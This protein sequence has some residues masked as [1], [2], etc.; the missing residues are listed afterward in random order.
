MV[1][2]WQVAVNCPLPHSFT[3]SDASL[4]IEDAAKLEPGLSV[5][6][7]FKNRKTLGVLLHSLS[8]KPKGDFEIRSLLAICLT[9]PKISSIYLKWLVW[10]ADYYLHPIG[11]TCELAFPP[12]AERH[13][14]RK[15]KKSKVVPLLRQKEAPILTAEQEQ[16]IAAISA[17]KGFGVHLVHGVTG[18]GKTEVYMQLFQKIMQN[19]GQGLLIVPEISLT[20]QLTQRVAERLGD[21]IALIHS[22]LTNRERTTEWWAAFSGDKSLLIGARS[23]LFCPMEKLGMIV[24][25]EE[26]EASFKQDEKLKYHARDAAIKL[27]QLLDIPIVLGSATPSLESYK[28]AIEARYFYYEL[29]NRVGF[30]SLPEIK[31]IDMRAENKT[32][33]ENPVDFLPHWLSVDLY[34]EMLITLERGDQVALFL[35]RRGMAQVVQCPSCGFIKHCPNCDISLTLHGQ[36]HLVC[37]YCDYHELYHLECRN[38]HDGEMVPLGLGTEQIEM[39][40]TKLFPNLSIARADRDEI[41]SRESLED[42]IR[43]I[44]NREVQI[45]IGTQ[46]IAKG[47]DFPHLKVVGLVAADVGLSVPD[48]RSGERGFQLITQMSGRSGRHIKPGE[49]P[50]QVFIQT[51]NPDHPSIIL[52]QKNAFA[53]FA[54]SALIEREEHLYPPYGRLI[55]VR[56]QG[57]SK[58]AVVKAAQIFF[59]RSKILQKKYKAYEAV[60]LLGPAE[61]PL[62]RIKNQ[63]RWHA[64]IKGEEHKVIHGFIKQLLGDEAWVPS[65]VRINPDVDPYHM[66]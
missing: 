21:S 44:E 23:S 39:D 56:F 30:R 35:N 16:V 15:S 24:V 22:H 53:D 47:L 41:N 62:A 27:A 14:Q 2:Y 42:L 4:S 37:H 33:K 5:E 57:A 43:A 10:L 36:R 50:G 46:M 40:L 25:D 51:Y 32:R 61:A 54:K 48:F 7:F 59:E 65:G 31:I 45:L 6:I 66:T 17:K 38:C 52:A 28:N 55:A 58:G 34:R 63:H 26:H 18:S 60:E 29:K 64:L 11:M 49:K 13:P 20:P 19:N 12:L 1:R 9:R 8:E 3:Y